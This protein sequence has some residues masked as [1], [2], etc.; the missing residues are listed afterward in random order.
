[1]MSAGKAEVVTSCAF[2][3]SFVAARAVACSRVRPW[4][5]HL[6][7]SRFSKMAIG[8]SSRIEMSQCPARSR[9]AGDCDVSGS[10]EGRIKDLG[11]IV[12]P[13]DKIYKAGRV[14]GI[15]RAFAIKHVAG[16]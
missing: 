10:V 15:R 16:D 7:I 6:S 3:K 11:F 14:K 1:M 9:C 5:T 2:G 4:E 13:F 12:Q 8:V